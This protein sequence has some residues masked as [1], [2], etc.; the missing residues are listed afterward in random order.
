MENKSFEAEINEILLH[1]TTNGWDKQYF[2]EGFDFETA[3]F[4]MSINMFEC[5]EISEYICEGIFKPFTEK[6]TR[7]NANSYCFRRTTRGRY[8]LLK[9]NHQMGQSGKRKK[10]YE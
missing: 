5:M 10:S 9:S 8:A 6:L 7:L 1:N 4:N 2:M 3:T